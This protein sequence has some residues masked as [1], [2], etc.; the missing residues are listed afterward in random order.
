MILRKECFEASVKH[1]D[2]LKL[3]HLRV[4]VYLVGH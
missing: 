1:L 4:I 3:D 2:G